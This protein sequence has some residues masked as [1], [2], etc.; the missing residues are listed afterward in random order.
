VVTRARAG[1]S[2]LGCLVLLLVAVAVGYFAVNAGE[3]YWRYY[4]FQ[5][6]MKQEARFAARRGDDLIARRLRAKADSLGLPP[7]AIRHLTIRRRPGAI[8]IGSEYYETIEL[9]LVVRQLRFA[10]KVESRF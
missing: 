10:P 4:R 1:R 6:A 5:D 8:R 9:P 7:Q 3:A 2:S